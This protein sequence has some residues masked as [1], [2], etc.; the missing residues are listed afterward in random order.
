MISKEN[1]KSSIKI[2]NDNVIN[3]LFKIWLYLFIVLESWN[4]KIKNNLVLQWKIPVEAG[5]IDIKVPYSPFT[6]L[7][8]LNMIVGTE[9]KLLSRDYK[10]TRKIFICTGA[11]H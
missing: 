4:N 9:S 8:V 6:V 5:L 1:V 11:Q 3:E 7:V 2:T 10:S